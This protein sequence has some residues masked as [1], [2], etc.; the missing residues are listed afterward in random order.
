MNNFYNV[1]PG[2]YLTNLL[3]KVI[4][5]TKVA[6]FLLCACLHLC[7]CMCSCMLACVHVCMCVY[8]CVCVCARVGYNLPLFNTLLA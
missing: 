2:E 1:I 6:L 4:R 3:N 5:R 8:I 7:V